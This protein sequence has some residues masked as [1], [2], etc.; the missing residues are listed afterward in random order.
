MR[1]QVAPELGGE[2]GAR[3]EDVA[4]EAVDATATLYTTDGGIDVDEQ[5][6]VQLQARGLT[7][8]ADTLAE[9]ARAIR[10]GHHVAVGEPDGSVEARPEPE[11]MP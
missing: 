9:L 4:Q 6:R 7:A 2:L 10:S 3:V 11:D 1:F 5:L 8:D